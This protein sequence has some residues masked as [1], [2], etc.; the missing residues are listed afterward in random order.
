MQMVNL[1]KSLEIGDIVKLF[2]QSTRCEDR[3]YCSGI[4]DVTF[5]HSGYT[6]RIS[7]FS[8]LYDYY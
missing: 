7:C 4:Q 6:Q 1:D 2:T 5:S 8:I 3:R